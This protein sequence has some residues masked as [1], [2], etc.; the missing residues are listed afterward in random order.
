[1]STLKLNPRIL[2]IVFASSLVLA[3]APG[4]GAAAATHDGRGEVRGGGF[5]DRGVR[6]AHTGHVERA[7]SANRPTMTRVGVHTGI[8]ARPLGWRFDPFW[9]YG[10]GYYGPYG[11]FAFSPWYSGPAYPQRIETTTP[12]VPADKAAVALDVHPSKAVITI[13]GEPAG[14][15]R[16]H[17]TMADALWLEPGRHVV[18]LSAD[19]RRTLRIEVDVEGGRAYDLRYELDKGAGLDARSS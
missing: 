14:R 16:D 15:A 1:M 10:Y 12:L 7:T 3:T 18:E 6:A 9:T 8:V 4:A 5:A 2:P 13:D 19:G 17:D 11:P